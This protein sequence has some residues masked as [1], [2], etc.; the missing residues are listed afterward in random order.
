MIANRPASAEIG[1]SRR[2][3][4]DRDQGKGFDLTSCAK[5]GPAVWG[6]GR[7]YF[8]FAGWDPRPARATKP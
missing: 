7:G 3:I 6:D 5:S 2:S 1:G 4:L 8:G